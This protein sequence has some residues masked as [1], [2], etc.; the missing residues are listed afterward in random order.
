[1]SSGTSKKNPTSLEMNSAAVTA[2]SCIDEFI[3]LEGRVG[4]GG[5]SAGSHCYSA[6]NKKSNLKFK[7]K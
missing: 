2:K 3:R 5:A 7:F 1:M 6:Q 4:G